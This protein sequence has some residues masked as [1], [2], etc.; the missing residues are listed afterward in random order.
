MWTSW[1]STACPETTFS[2]SVSLSV[3]SFSIVVD[4]F[5]IHVYS[6]SLSLFSPILLDGYFMRSRVPSLSLFVLF[7]FYD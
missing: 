6:G 7:F 2:R 4:F 1:R 3:F 5:I